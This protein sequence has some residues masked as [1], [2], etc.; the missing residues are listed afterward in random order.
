MVVHFDASGF[1]HVRR[2]PEGMDQLAALTR[3][4]Q[5]VFEVAPT[6]DV[7]QLEYG[8]PCIVK[9][10]FLFFIFM[11]RLV[12]KKIQEILEML[13]KISSLSESTGRAHFVY[14]QSINQSINQSI[15]HSIRRPIN[16]L[17]KQSCLTKQPINQMKTVCYPHY[18][19]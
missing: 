11:R 2:S 7:R 14:C 4:W 8:T 17:T 3:S 10:V 1:L 18:S 9:L 19:N 6:L 15:R 5:K 12:N 13:R 16:Q